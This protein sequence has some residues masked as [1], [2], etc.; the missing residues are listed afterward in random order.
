MKSGEGE[1]ENSDRIGSSPSMRRSQSSARFRSG[2]D[3]GPNEGNESSDRI[4]SSPSM[5]RSS[6]SARFASHDRLDSSLSHQS[7]DD[8]QGFRYVPCV[9]V[10]VWCACVCAVC[11]VLTCAVGQ[12]VGG[13]PVEL[14]PGDQVSGA[15]QGDAAQGEGRLVPRFHGDAALTPTPAR[16]HRHHP[17]RAHG[18]GTSHP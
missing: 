8:S 14:L 10:C 6:S 7:L 9:C 2:S 1:G 11:A 17:R 3:G 12:A 5:K 16:Q 13:G 18:P 4:G 15:E